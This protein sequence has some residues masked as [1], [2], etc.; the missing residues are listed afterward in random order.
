MHVCE[1]LIFRFACS[2]FKKTS[3]TLS[4]AGQKTSAA[5]STLGS[6]ISRRFE[7]MRYSVMSHPLFEFNSL[8]HLVKSVVFKPV[9]SRLPVACHEGSYR[10]LYPS[11]A[12][13]YWCISTFI[14]L[15]GF[16]LCRAPLIFLICLCLDF[17]FKGE[18]EAFSTRTWILKKKQINKKIQPPFYTYAGCPAMSGTCQTKRWCYNP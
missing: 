3:E 7:D 15:G 13:P 11:E 10:Q 2:R 8:T 5:F 1:R 14:L 16:Y 4:T 6:A 9:F 18:A 12:I 17:F